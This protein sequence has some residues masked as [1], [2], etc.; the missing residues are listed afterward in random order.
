MLYTI[1]LCRTN[2]YSRFRKIK[3]ENASNALEIG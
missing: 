3:I 1:D 2:P